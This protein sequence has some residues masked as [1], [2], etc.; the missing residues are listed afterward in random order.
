MASLPSAPSA[1]SSSALCL[2]SLC[3]G[4]QWRRQGFSYRVGGSTGQHSL[5]GTG[6][7]V[8][9]CKEEVNNGR[10]RALHPWSAN[11]YGNPGFWPTFPIGFCAFFIHL[12]F[13]C[14]GL[15]QRPNS[16]IALLACNVVLL[17]Q[18]L[19]PRSVYGDPH[20]PQELGRVGEQM[21]A[22]AQWGYMKTASD[23]G[24]FVLCAQ[25]TASFNS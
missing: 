6:S 13:Q 11:Q 12:G 1:K 14:S 22:I 21:V 7:D 8:L 20:G 2:R 9:A 17:F 4:G 23:G 19:A 16:R 25:M 18:C 24:M 5:P 3:P 15:Q 10:E